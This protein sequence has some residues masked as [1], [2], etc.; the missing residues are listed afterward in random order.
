MNGRTDTRRDT[1]AFLLVLLLFSFVSV[2]VSDEPND[3][4]EGFLQRMAWRVTWNDSRLTPTLAH[5]F[6]APL[7]SF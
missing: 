6:G 1:Y 5:I 2:F 4:L 3:L 7:L